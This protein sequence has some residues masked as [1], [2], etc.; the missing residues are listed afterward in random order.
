MTVTECTSACSAAGYQ[1]AGVEYASK[2]RLFPPSTMIVSLT[3]YI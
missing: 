3:T 1:L 2:I